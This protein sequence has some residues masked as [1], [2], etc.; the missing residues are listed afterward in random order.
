M[1]SDKMPYIIYADVEFLVKKIGGYTNNP[2][3][4]STTKIGEDSPCGYSVS[5]IWVFDHIEDKHTLYCAKDC[6]KKCC[7]SLREQAKNIIDF[8]KK[9]MLL[10]TKEELK[11]H[12]EAKVC[13]ICGK[14]KK[15]SK[16]TNYRK[17]RDHY[18]YTG[19]YRSAAHNICNSKFNVPY[20]IPVAF[21]NDSN[22]DY[23]FI[24][25]ELA[26]KLEGRFECLGENT[27]KYKTFSVLLEKHVTKVDKDGI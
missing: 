18:H 15:L 11:S 13:Y 6:M 9:K 5:T 1:K 2:E 25:K 3:N 19:R 8:E 14:R 4:S 12:Q 20:E 21:H 27:E 24:I 17:V 22:C 16:S 7:E 23:H 26:N 10:L